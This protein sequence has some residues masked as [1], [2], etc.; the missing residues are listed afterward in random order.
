MCTSDAPVGVWDSERE[1]CEAFCDQKQAKAH[2][3]LCKCKACD[4]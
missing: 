3:K 2:C 4:M 1:Q